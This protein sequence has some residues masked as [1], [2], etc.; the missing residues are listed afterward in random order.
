MLFLLGISL[1]AVSQT[2]TAINSA[3]PAVNWPRHETLA[4]NQIQVRF[5]QN[6]LLAGGNITFTNPINSALPTGD[7]TV[8]INGTNVPIVAATV[9]QS[10]V[11]QV[12]FNATTANFLAPF[13]SHG[14][15]IQYNDVVTIS[16]TN[17]SATLRTSGSN[18]P[19]A[20]FSNLTS[21]NNFEI[22]SCAQDILSGGVGPII[23]LPQNQCGNS[24]NW[25]YYQFNWRLSLRF[26]NSLN[27][28]FLGVYVSTSYG[29][30][31][32]S[33]NALVHTD[34]YFNLPNASN[35]AIF[36]TAGVGS[37]PAVIVSARPTKVYANAFPVNGTCSWTASVT[38]IFGSTGG[39]LSCT[40]GLIQTTSVYTY[41]T[42]N[43]NSG[44]LAIGPQNVFGQD[45]VCVNSQV[46]TRFSDNTLLNC[47]TPIGIPA[48]NVQDR[49]VR[50][51]Y[52]SQNWTAPSNIPDIRVVPPTLPGWPTSTVQV[53]NNDPLGSLIFPGGFSFTGVGGTEVPDANGAILVPNPVN[54]ASGTRYMA[55]IITT[56]TNNQAVGQRLWV[57]MDYWDICNP[58][59]DP[60]TG[61]P[62]GPNGFSPPVST[63]WYVSIIGKPAPLS[64]NGLSL[65]WNS[66]NTTAGI[67]F[68]AIAN[69]ARTGV[70]WYRSNPKTG[71]TQISSAIAGTNS[72]TFPASSYTVANGFAVNFQRNLTNGAYYSVWATQLNGP[73]GTTCESEPI[74][75]VIFQQPDITANVAAFTLGQSAV[76]N[77]PPVNNQPY[78][79]TVP[80]TSKV[81]NINTFTNGTAVTLA[82]DNFWTQGF[83]A[84]V[85]LS[86][87]QGGAITAGFNLAAQPNPS[88]TNNITVGLQY[89]NAPGVTVT[90]PITGAAPLPA[91]YTITPQTNCPNTTVNRAVTVWGQSNGG[92]ISGNQI[93]CEGSAIAPITVA[94]FRGSIQSWEVQ[95]NGGG[96]SVD[97]SVGTAA[98]I[99]PSV[100]IVGGLQTVY[101]Y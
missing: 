26:R 22:S 84:G 81:I 63:S 50:I 91:N 80:T 5:N 86:P 31:T 85:S 97:G 101:Q 96:F 35:T 39:G 28:N 95:V 33:F 12:T 8:T 59:I 44:T 30:L 42:D 67:D 18:N 99:T 93:V 1:S 74:E 32:S 15:Y 55:N 78:A 27:Y 92:A 89:V 77:G 90:S 88:V 36:P 7:W 43:A 60:S 2:A 16:F 41:D 87:T 68:T 19:A 25:N 34:G 71:G 58:Y 98:T 76:C 69:G 53:T 75:I 73:V 61:L 6:G 82:T 100:P 24:I 46:N 20:V 40:G 37:T 47:R 10:D 66:T 9:V 11:V 62:G 70:N 38:P 48:P 4:Q 83:G 3:P 51:V 17:A 29:D 72:L 14:N 23:G 56:L 64:T 52:G 79:A 65:C 57:R 54:A 45:L 13:T 21:T 94:G 49:Y